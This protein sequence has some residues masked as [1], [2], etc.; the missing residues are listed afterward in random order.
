[1]TI[2]RRLLIFLALI[3]S[4]ALTS[5][6]QEQDKKLS[7]DLMTIAE[8]I[9]TSTRAI[10]QAR[11]QMEQAA[12][13]DT[14]NVKANFL[15]GFWHIESIGKDQSIIFFLR[16]YRQNPNYRFDLE[17]WIGK[18]YHYG[19]RFDQAIEFYTRYKNKLTAKSGY[20][21]KDK[22]DMSEEDRRIIECNNAQ[23]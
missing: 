21:G 22:M 1:M 11:D 4:A 5:Q 6:A 3:L 23:E 19:E 15:A 13:F 14:T 10:D 20:A 8:E 9:M 7:Q 2:S 18:G 17:Y 12:N 16:V